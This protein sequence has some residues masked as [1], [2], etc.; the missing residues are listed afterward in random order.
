MITSSDQVKYPFSLTCVSCDT[1]GD[2]DTPEQAIAEGW[3]EIV[4]AID[5]P[6]ANYCGWCPECRQEDQ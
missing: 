4:E 3:T 6:M 5:L 1:G 2:I